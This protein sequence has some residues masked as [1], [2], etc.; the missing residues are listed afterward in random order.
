MAVIIV[1]IHLRARWQAVGGGSEGESSGRGQNRA[2]GG[3]MKK[4]DWFKPMVVVISKSVVKTAAWG[5]MWRVTVGGVVSMTD[6]VTD[7]FVVWQYWEGGEKMLKYRN[8][9]LASLTTSIALQLLLVGMQ[10]RKKG[11]RRILKEMAY[12]ITGLKVPLH[13]YIFDNRL[14]EC[15]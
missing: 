4:H 3:L 14:R 9:S 11:V 5:L 2:V 1:V 13:A 7:L 8:A 6:L 10:N 12:V 15:Y